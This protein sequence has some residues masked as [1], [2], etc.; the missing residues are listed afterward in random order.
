MSRW[1]RSPMA[2]FFITGVIISIAL[3][4]GLFYIGLPWLFAYLI[5]INLSTMLF[6]GYDKLKAG[7]DGW[8]VPERVLHML[9]LLGGSP[10]AFVSQKLFRHK[11]IKGSFRV[12]F[13]VIIMIQI[14]VVAAWFYLNR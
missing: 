8:R 13:W 14:I 3:T 7:K 5:A 6:Y 12:W 2:V 4:I 10:T 9:A 1:H 11:T